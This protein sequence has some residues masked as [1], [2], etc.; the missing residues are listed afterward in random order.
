MVALLGATLSVFFLWRGRVVFLVDA[1]Y[2]RTI[3]RT[4]ERTL[5]KRLLANGYLLSCQEIAL[6]EFDEHL[7]TELAKQR[8]TKPLHIV[9]SPL[10]TELLPRYDLAGLENVHL[11]GIGEAGSD[12]TALLAH[13]VPAKQ[14]DWPQLEK[15]LGTSGSALVL[16]SEGQSAHAYDS[17]RTIVQQEAESD[18]A[19]SQRLETLS[20]ER[21]LMTLFVPQM[22]SWAM[23]LL[24]GRGL[25]WVVDA[26][27]LPLVDGPFLQGVVCDDLSEGL[28]S[29]LTG[30]GSTFQLAKRY[31]TEQEI[32]GNL[33]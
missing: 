33:L 28:L 29:V 15:R 25:S 1:T 9:L 26:A 22:G 13:L 18:Q 16:T 17:S 32:G 5:R 19:F 24:S 31:F 7:L 30:Q 4:N 3:Y 10:L 23:P 8:Q 11:I 20:Q 14:F 2:C 6:G 27:Y 21:S 12:A